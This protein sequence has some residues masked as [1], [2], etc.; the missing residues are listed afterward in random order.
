VLFLS[1]KSKKLRNNKVVFVENIS[2]NNAILTTGSGSVLPTQTNTDQGQRY[3]VLDSDLCRIRILDE[4]ERLTINYGGGR[5][6]AKLREMGGQVGSAPACYG[7]SLGSY[8]DIF[9]K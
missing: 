7:S 1:E 3:A 4:S 6:L 5:W 9:K 8:P 2:I